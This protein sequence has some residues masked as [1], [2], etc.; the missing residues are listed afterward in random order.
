MFF[1]VASTLASWGATGAAGELKSPIAVRVLRRLP[2]RCLHDPH[3]F[4]FG[5][6]QRL[7]RLDKF[8]LGSRLLPCFYSTTWLWL[9]SCSLSR[10]AV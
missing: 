4:E 2:R 5:A 6:S 10:L 9:L 8:T 3:A 7:S 1:S